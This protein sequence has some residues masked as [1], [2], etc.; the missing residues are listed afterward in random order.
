MNEGLGE[1]LGS[2]QFLFFFYFYSLVGCL[3]GKRMEDEDALIRHAVLVAVVTFFC[4][5]GRRVGKIIQLPKAKKD[6]WMVLTRRVVALQ[7]MPY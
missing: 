6:G 1:A 4:G 3:W 5:I 2:I 7:R